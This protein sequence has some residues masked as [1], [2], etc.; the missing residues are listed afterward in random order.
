MIGINRSDSE[1]YYQQ[2]YRQIAEAI[3][4]GLY[5]P[6]EQLPSLRQHATMLSVSRNTVEQA[7]QLLT[8]EG[9]V[10][11]RPGSGYV[12]NSRDIKPR[13]TDGY[14][15][16]YESALLL[17]QERSRTSDIVFEYDFAYDVMDS[18]LF[19]YLQWTR[20]A[21]NVLQSAQVHNICSYGDR[22]GLLELRQQISDYLLR[23]EDI[24][25]VPEQ[26]LILPNTRAAIATALHLFDAHTTSVTVENPAFPEIVNV[27]RELGFAVR[28]HTVYPDNSWDT[29]IAHD[30]GSRLVICTPSNQYPTN[31]IMSLQDRIDLVKWANENDAYI[32]E[33]AYCHEFRY[34]HDHLPS[35]HAL[36]RDGRIIVMGTFSKSLAPSI[37][38]SY[39]VLPP[40]LMLR[41]MGPHGIM[42]SPVPWQMQATLA[43]FIRT[44]NW[45]QHL[46]RLQTVYRQKYHALIDALESTMGTHID[47]L[48]YENGLHMLITTRDGRSAHDLYTQAAK[49][50]VRLYRTEQDFIGDVPRGWRYLLLGYAA[51][52]LE[53]IRP[54]VEALARAWGF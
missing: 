53:K 17:L 9:F 8:Q 40:Q 14:S 48:D 11:A 47:Y 7:Y 31:A 28:P 41:W 25:A 49:A 27:C 3:E 42:H 18:S 1:P 30:G 32:I 22:Q 52:P 13:R 50:G 5:H 15:A 6:G 16:E 4:Q 24:R 33:D 10:D 39:L 20:A 43:E 46:H 54:G 44:D 26:I 35:L 34:Q 38:I 12:V 23:E 19:P 45:Y 51:I 2:I 21:R 37:C 29:F 36:D